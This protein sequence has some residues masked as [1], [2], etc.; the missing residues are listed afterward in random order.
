MEIK[1]IPPPS[2][3]SNLQLTLNPNDQDV[4]FYLLF[5]LDRPAAARLVSVLNRV[6]SGNRIYKF[7]DAFIVEAE[8]E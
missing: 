6:Y 3:R 7:D 8:D 5:S 1:T 4:L 2:Q